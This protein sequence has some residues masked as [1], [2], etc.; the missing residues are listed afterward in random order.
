ML[1]STIGAS[2]RN[3]VAASSIQRH[4]VSSAGPDQALQTL[5]FDALDEG[6][7]RANICKSTSGIESTRCIFLGD[8]YEV[9][10]DGKRHDEDDTVCT[11]D[12][13]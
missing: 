9:S 10:F 12:S 1:F 7:N 8:G 6:D 2:E 13:R 3:N 5:A 4:V 11:G